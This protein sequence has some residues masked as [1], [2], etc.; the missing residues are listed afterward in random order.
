LILL[1]VE[2][3]KRLKSDEGNTN[4]VISTLSCFFNMTIS[5]WLTTMQVVF[6]YWLNNIN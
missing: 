6:F 4:I 5:C 3:C 2:P 1:F